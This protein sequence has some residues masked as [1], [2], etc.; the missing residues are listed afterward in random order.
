MRLLDLPDDVLEQVA[1][2]RLSEG[3]GRAL[4]QADGHDAQRRLAR[5]AVGESWT[6]RRTEAAAREEAAARTRARTRRAAGAGWLDDDVRN[7]LTD[8]LYRALGVAVRIHDEA[9]GARVELRLASPEEAA[10]LLERL[11]GSNAPPHA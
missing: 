7:D 3:H 4:L 10:A 11:S 9:A 1:T 8:A 2:G 5:R 6:V